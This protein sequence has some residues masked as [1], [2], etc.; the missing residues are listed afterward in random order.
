MKLRNKIAA[1]ILA[2]CVAASSL[3]L[4]ALA[5]GAEA[6]GA[7]AAAGTTQP[8]E[9]AVPTLS[10]GAFSGG[11]SVIYDKITKRESGY[12]IT[13]I[14]YIPIDNF[15]SSLSSSYFNSANIFAFATATDSFNPYTPNAWE[16]ETR[17]VG[18]FLCVSTRF[19]DVIYL[20]NGNTFN[21]NICYTSGEE[22]VNVPIS[23]SIA[24]CVEY[25][26]EEEEETPAEVIDAA[27]ALDSSS[28]P[29]VK[30]GS[31]AT[32]SAS[33]KLINGGSFSKIS[34]SLTSADSTVIV[35]ETGAK[36]SASSAPSFSFRISVPEEAAAGIY[37]LSLTTTVYSKKGVP[38]S[39]ETYQLPVKVTSDIVSA[40]LSVTDYK[41]SKKNVKKGDSFNLTL[42]LKNSCGI[43]LKDVKVSLDGLDS[44]K[45]VLDGGFSS[46]SVDIKDGKT[47]S[48][49]FPLVACA[50]IMNVREN[51]PVQASYMIDPS[52]ASTAQTLNT[53][54]IVECKPEEE[55]KDEGKY[56]ISLTDYSFSSAAVKKGT[57][58]TLEF[59]L[60]NVS[61]TDVKGGRV[62]LL[63]LTGSKFA[64]DSGLTYADFDLAAGKS[65][66]FSF[67][68]VG[69]DGIT[70]IRE[71]IPVEI[72]FGEQM[73]TVYTTVTCVPDETKKDDEEQQ[74]FAPAIIIESYDFGGEYVTGGT[75][76]PLS[77][78]VK[79]T[80]SAAPI[81]NLK[82]TVSGGAGN[83]DSGI[84]FSP[85]NSSNSFFIERLG[86]KE[87]T[88]IALDLLPR[89][90]AKPDSY[91][92]ILT[93]EYEYL[94]NGKRAKAETITETITIPLQQEDRFTIN[95]PEYPESCGVG[96]MAYISVSFINKGKSGVYNVIADIEGEGFTKTSSSYYVGNVNSGAEEYYDVQITPDM[97]GTIEANIVVT[98]EDANGTEREQRAPITISAISYNYDFSYDYGGMVDIGMEEMPVDEGSDMTWLWFVIGG[99]A[100]AA[101]VVIIVVAVVKKKKKQ[102][103]LELDDEDI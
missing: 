17:I 76:F 46:Q 18:S 59:T 25:V 67:P 88:E 11:Y 70:S 75:T 61:K 94:A 45:F 63:E 39:T 34:A 13:T 58:F 4:S 80:S 84:A 74:V 86:G 21:Y 16:T 99:V 91:P 52:N 90:D 68:L 83:G 53:S 66:K 23:V 1:A 31:N 33:L 78:I 42:K 92:V 6:G 102:R 22:G 5:E 48:I 65:K 60:K 24:E 28:T 7:G 43:D 73:Q 81:E 27:F 72:S 50:G 51:I 41:V 10:G 44:T 8:S 96:E 32:I 82:V 19:I 2:A 20:G 85:A 49:T 14:T 93:F 79:N 97:E 37:T 29:T 35:E 69:C 100:V 95:Q 30:A 87:T 55:K 38:V 40:G 15:D 71:V 54:V 103:E 12:D 77:V 47:A 101:V 62:S 36:T 9:P 3:P 89:A 57:K 98:Y 26:E 64:I 56:D